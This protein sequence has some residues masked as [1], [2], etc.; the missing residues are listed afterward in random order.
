MEFKRLYENAVNK[1]NIINIITRVINISNFKVQRGRIRGNK[2][3]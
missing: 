3:I 1:I 2:E